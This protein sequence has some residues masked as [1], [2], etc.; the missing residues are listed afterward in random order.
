M[1][2][3]ELQLFATRAYHEWNRSRYPKTSKAKPFSEYTA[4][5]KVGMEVRGTRESIGVV[6]REDLFE[7][8]I[9]QVLAES[10]VDYYLKGCVK[11]VLTDGVI[12]V[13]CNEEPEHLLCMYVCMY[14]CMHVCSCR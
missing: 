10:E 8:K 6:S 3:Q 2:V 4:E 12:S 14:V 9:V 11:I 13:N 7:G 5:L 1:I